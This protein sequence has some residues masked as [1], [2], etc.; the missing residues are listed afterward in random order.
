MKLYHAPQ[1]RSGRILWLLE[2][3]GVDYDVE[4]V[5][6][7][8]PNPPQAF[9]DASPLGKVPALVD[10]DVVVAD[11]AAICLYVADRYRQASLAPAIDA[12]ERGEYLFWMIYTPGV[13][14]PAM[15]ELA[16]GTEPQ[17][18]RNG[19]GSFDKM[20]STLES[21]LDGSDWLVGNRFSAADVMNGSSVAFMRQFDMLPKSP[22]LEAYADRC[23]ERPA[24]Q[25]AMSAG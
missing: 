6:L 14:E 4:T 11:S 24:Y 8:D 12:P 15:A 2:E 7:G 22:V 18:R 21:R 5:T 20:I 1:T 10:G 17:P 16:A 13:I 19:W 23:A 9:L 25:K 3:A